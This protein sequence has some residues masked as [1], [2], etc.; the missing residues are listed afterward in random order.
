MQRNGNGIMNRYVLVLNQSYEPVMVTSAKRA[1]VLMHLEKAEGVV[2]YD[3]FVH[4][5]SV[6]MPLP[7]IV[8]LARYVQLRARDIVLSRKNIFKRDNHRCQ[9][10][11]TTSVP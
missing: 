4:S 5:P 2:N 6:T 9:Y 10:C 1:V 11:G 7:S 3:E 8:R